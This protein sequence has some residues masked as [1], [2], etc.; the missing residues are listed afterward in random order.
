LAVKDDLERT[1]KEEP[2][3]GH[4][5][6]MDV[7]NVC[8]NVSYEVLRSRIYPPTLYAAV[9][10]ASSIHVSDGPGKYPLETFRTGPRYIG[11]VS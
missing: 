3:P 11:P 4:R 2:Q 8:C 10:N 9:L 6:S 5:R 1:K 7:H